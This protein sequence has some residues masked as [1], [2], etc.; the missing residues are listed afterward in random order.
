MSSTS[1]IG[2]REREGELGREEEA[3][4]GE[5]VRVFT[6]VA[7]SKGSV[8]RLRSSSRIFEDLGGVY[9]SEKKR[10]S[11]GFRWKQ[12]ELRFSAGF[13]WKRKEFGFSASTGWWK[14]R[15]SWLKPYGF[16][17][18]F[19]HFLKV[20]SMPLENST[21]GCFD[22]TPL[23]S[24]AS[25]PLQLKFFMSTLKNLNTIHLTAENHLT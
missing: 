22:A 2:L 15:L 8:R 13:R 6:K 20:I 25:I 12:K 7:P 10:F 11:A 19:V 4:E 17:C 14:E 18:S 3:C 5:F 9:F 1:A 16:H 24:G 23:V 21:S